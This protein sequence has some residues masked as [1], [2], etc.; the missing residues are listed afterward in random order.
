MVLFSAMKIFALY[1]DCVHEKNVT[2]PGERYI[3]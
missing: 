2:I 3:I 1:P